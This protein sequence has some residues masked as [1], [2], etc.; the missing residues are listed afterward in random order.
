MRPANPASS[1]PPAPGGAETTRPGGS[2]LRGY[3]VALSGTVAAYLAHLALRPVLADQSSPVLF[4]IPIALSAW[5]GGV[6]PSLAA[7]ALS[8][9][10]LMATRLDL[11]GGALLRPIDLLDLGLMAAAGALIC[12]LAESLRRAQ[13]HAE[14]GRESVAAVPDAEGPDGRRG[15][16][17]RRPP[18]G[19]AILSAEA[20]DSNSTPT[21]VPGKKYS[22]RAL[23]R[24]VPDA[25][26]W[27]N[28][29]GEFIGRVG[30]ETPG[31]S[32]ALDSFLGKHYRDVLPRPAAD[33]L[34]GYLR[35]EGDVSS[36][37][38]GRSPQVQTVECELAL[39]GQ[40]TR[41]FELRLVG[42]VEG[43]A[44]VL[45]RDVTEWKR[46][47]EDLRVSEG[48]YRSLVESSAD[49]I[50]VNRGGRIVYA[51]PALLKLVEAQSLEQ[52]IGKSPFDILHPD[53]HAVVRERIR[54]LLD[55]RRAV[56]FL[57]MKYLKLDGTPVDVEVAGVP[58][59]DHGEPAIHVTARDIRERKR[60]AESLRASEAR[61]QE[62][63]DHAAD[64]LFLHDEHG[65]IVDVNRQACASL[66][67]SRED[68][69]GMSPFAFDPDATPAMFEQIAARL[70]AGEV[71]A[72]DSRHRRKDGTV[73][74]VEVRIRPF[75]WEGRRLSLALARDIT[76]RK[77]AEQALVESHG[78]LNAVVEGT[79]DAVFVKDLQG[80]YLM[81]NSAGAR[82]VGRPV[83]EVLGKDDRELFSPETARR[84]M[85]RDLQVMASGQMQTLE[86]TAT[87]AGVTRTYLS[88]K[89]ALRDAEGRWSASS[90]SPATSRS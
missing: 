4:L 73:F 83:A 43:E 22:L 14:A 75:E 24:A 81:I 21:G 32:G 7:L 15:G 42:T 76:E 8:A 65:V 5:L 63:V 80:R 34:A 50:F 1:E 49:G 64:G 66:G 30:G 38:G 18:P 13:M 69:I 3:T 51:N 37:L 60:A 9:F 85:E 90:A 56:P 79:A 57:E 29:A 70:A 67:Y 23:I 53:Y 46:A 61:F 54:T 47:E 82:F 87:A 78:L 52:V 25:A 27:L 11:A 28:T 39:P 84:I 71:V 33:F 10:A 16:A 17:G 59:E 19:P 74:P 45:F 77:R 88:T 2:L 89:S 31:I 40:G 48:R 12:G 72:F 68:L 44:L 55:T 26:F 41:D 36:S 58:F 35:R 86:E 6:G 20:P 62:L